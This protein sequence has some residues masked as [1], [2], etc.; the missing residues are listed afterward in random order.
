MRTEGTFG[1]VGHDFARK[2]WIGRVTGYN[3]ARA[4]RSLGVAR[5]NACLVLLAQGEL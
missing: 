1:L 3:L 2:G 5:E 4:A